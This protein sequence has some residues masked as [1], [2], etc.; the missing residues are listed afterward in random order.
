MEVVNKETVVDQEKKDGKFIMLGDIGAAKENIRIK[1][2]VLRM[3]KVPTFMNPYE[4][5]SIELVLVDEKVEYVNVYIIY[6][7]L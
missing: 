7:L 2:R 6:Y 4:T 3:W 5:N 1:V